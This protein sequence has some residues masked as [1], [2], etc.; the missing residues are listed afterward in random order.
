MP[1]S[2]ERDTLHVEGRD[3]TH[4]IIHL[5]KRHGIDYD[6][7]RWQLPEVKEAGSVEMLLRLVEPVVRASTGRTVAFVLDANTALSRRWE[8]VRGR[9]DTAGVETPASPPPE[10][11][12]GSSATYGTRVGVWLMPD[13]CHDGA[14]EDFLRTL[15]DDRDPLIGHAERAT[16]TAAEIDR[17]FPPADRLKAILH[18]WLAWQREPGRPYGTAVGARFFRHDSPAALAFLAWFK[19]LFSVS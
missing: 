18:T 4:T 3:D 6:A 17:R 7:R 16:D 5:L 2:M 10:G 9:L 12:V 13:N 1:E 14:L 11:F 19:R 8:A 15:V